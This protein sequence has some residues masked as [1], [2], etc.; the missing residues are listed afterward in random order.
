MR[1]LDLTIG[2]FT[3]SGASTAFVKLTG[4][5]TVCLCGVIR[6]IEQVGRH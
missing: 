1:I 6:L 4:F 3:Q 5:I 2:R